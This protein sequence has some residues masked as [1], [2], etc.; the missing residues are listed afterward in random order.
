MIIL[1]IYNK[2]IKLIYQNQIILFVYYNK[3]IFQFLVLIKEIFKYIK[4]RIYKNLE[5][6][7]V[8]IYK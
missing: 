4:V 8:I 1:I 2:A 6:L 5:I 3:T 7:K